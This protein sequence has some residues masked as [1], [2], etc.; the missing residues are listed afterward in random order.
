MMSAHALDRLLNIETE[1]HIELNDPAAGALRVRDGEAIDKFV[2]HEAT[3]YVGFRQMLRRA[4]IDLADH[5][6]VDLGCGLGRVVINAATYPFQR[7]IGVEFSTS[8]AAVAR[9]NV[10]N[11]RFLRFRTPVEIVCLDARSFA[12]GPGNYVVYLFNPFGDSVMHEIVEN[13]H[14]AMDEHRT[15]ITVIYYNN[16]HHNMFERSPRFRRVDDGMVDDWSAPRG[17]TF[18]IFQSAASG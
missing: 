11:A 14:H 1:R 3:S 15:K 12:F 10:Q 16:K 8:L 4:P 6:F 17:Y 9:R 13:M 5:T 18:T 7:V 2:H